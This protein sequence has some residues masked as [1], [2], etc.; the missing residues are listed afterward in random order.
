MLVRTE[1]AISGSRF[2]HR[3][4]VVRMM[5]V[6]AAIM[7]AQAASADESSEQLAREATDPTA[8]LMAFNFIGNYVGD[9]QGPSGGQSDDTVEVSFRPVIPFNAFGQSNILRLTVPYLT[10]GRGEKGIGDVTLFD[11][12]VFNESWGRWGVGPV[13]TLASDDNAPDDFVIGPAIGAVWRYSKQLNLGLFNQNV[14]GSDTRISQIQPVIAYQ[15][16]HGWSV[17]AGDLQF[18]YD[19]EH[20]R[21]LSVPVG[22]QI[23]KVTR[24]GDQPVRVAFAPQY[25]F[26]DHDGLPKWSAQFTFTVL[27]PS[28]AVP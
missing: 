12:V 14:F 13:M 16:G 23:G 24:I 11:L 27:V 28:L 26:A 22:F 5:I 25:N 10:A 8:S 3:S 4:A 18:V 1:W 6:G 2:N 21:W 7:V 17:S 20:E 15:L 19:W 9:Y